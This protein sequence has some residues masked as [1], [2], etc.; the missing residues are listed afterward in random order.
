M[1]IQKAGVLAL[2]KKF[3]YQVLF[4]QR[5]VAK[6]GTDRVFVIALS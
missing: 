5:S 6:L 1:A 2:F 4:N 3:L